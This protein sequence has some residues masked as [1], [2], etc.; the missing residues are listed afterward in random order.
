M[1]KTAWDVE[2]QGSR[3]R[4]G[5]LLR[6]LVAMEDAA[7]ASQGPARLALEGGH[8]DVV[9]VPQARVYLEANYIIYMFTIRYDREPI[10]SDHVFIG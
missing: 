8:H 4:V 9:H 2:A 1:P 7:D 6:A 10:G 3:G 5:A